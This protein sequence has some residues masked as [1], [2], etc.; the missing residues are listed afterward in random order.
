MWIIA[1]IHS[2]DN[3]SCAVRTVLYMV[4]VVKNT[5]VLCM[6]MNI[7][8]VFIFIL[9][10][11]YLCASHGLFSNNAMRLIDSSPIKQVDIIF[12]P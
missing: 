7:F 6:L 8:P 5:I 11:I 3:D 12:V 2:I 1:S 9:R 4:V 10:N